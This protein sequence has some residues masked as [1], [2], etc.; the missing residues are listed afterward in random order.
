M[1]IGELLRASQLETYRDLVNIEHANASACAIYLGVEQN[2]N[3]IIRKYKL[4]I[5][6]RAVIL[7]TEMFPETRFQFPP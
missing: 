7:I 2:S 4:H 5:N 3:V 6:K 1:G